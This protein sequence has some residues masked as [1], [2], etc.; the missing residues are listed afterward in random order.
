MY[1]I[2]TARGHR[3]GPYVYEREETAQAALLKADATAQAVWDL[4]Y[5]KPPTSKHIKL[6]LPSATFSVKP[7]SVWE[8][9][10]G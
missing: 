7:L 8:H 4:A 6:T 1:E 9:V 10:D 2:S 3:W 5:P